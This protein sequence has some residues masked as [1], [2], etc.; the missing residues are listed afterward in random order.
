MTWCLG[1]QALVLEYLGE[2]LTPL[3]N[4]RQVINHI[5]PQFSHLESSYNSVYPIHLGRLKERKGSKH[6]WQ[7]F[8]V[9]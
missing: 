9:Q 7:M 6:I 4:S 1:T 8:R 2:N 5:K 3:V